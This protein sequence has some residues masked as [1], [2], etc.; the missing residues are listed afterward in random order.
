MKYLKNFLD[1]SPVKIKNTTYPTI[2]LLKPDR[3]QQNIEAT[4]G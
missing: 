3:L 1:K 4:L 2:D